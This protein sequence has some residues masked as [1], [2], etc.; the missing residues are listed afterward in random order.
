MLWVCI[1]LR[2]RNLN[3]EIQRKGQTPGA[4]YREYRLAM[5]LFFCVSPLDDVVATMDPRGYLE[6]RG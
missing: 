4:A 3:E 6:V 5:T 1:G 2:V